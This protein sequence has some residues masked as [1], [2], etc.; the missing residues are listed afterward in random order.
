[1]REDER[2]IQSTKVLWTKKWC[3]FNLR[4]HVSPDVISGIC[5]LIQENCQLYLKK[6][7]IYQILTI[8]VVLQYSYTLAIKV[9]KGFS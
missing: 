4:V 8:R 6:K 9:L 2:E 3:P 5:A 1:M 7:P